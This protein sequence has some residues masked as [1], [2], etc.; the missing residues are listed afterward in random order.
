VQR[1]AGVSPTRGQQVGDS[2]PQWNGGPAALN[3]PAFDPVNRIAYIQVADGCLGATTIAGWPDQAE[4]AAAAGI[5]RVGQ[6][7]GVQAQR[8][9][10]SLPPVYSI[11]AMNVDTGERLAQFVD[12]N[13]SSLGQ[14]GVLLTAGGVAIAGTSTG[15][16]YVFDASTLEVL[17][18][19]NVGAEIAA[20]FSTW[21]VNGE[22]QFGVMV[23]GNGNGAWQKSAFGVVF[24]LRD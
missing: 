14:T 20:P 5:N 1:Y 9:R 15:D 17:W 11:Y 18:S 22:Q 13:E 10:P 24:G 4:A 7:A 21:S 23:G 8:E 3:P 2:C 16:V 19:F 6:G 12:P